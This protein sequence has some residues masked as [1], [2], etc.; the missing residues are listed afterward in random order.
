M[1]C[2]NR[3]CVSLFEKL[4]ITED[5]KKNLELEARK[6][7]L[8]LKITKEKVLDPLNE[9]HSTYHYFL[10][11]PCPFYNKKLSCSIHKNKP[12]MCQIFP[13]R[14]IKQISK[15]EYYFVIDPKCNW[16][17]NNLEIL[18]EPFRNLFNI[19]KNEFEIYLNS[20]SKILYLSL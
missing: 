19:F 12:V 13:I 11:L 7:N 10:H 9:E 14:N 20:I 5:E 4:Q 1:Q 6:R 16:V 18:E 15:K 3:C 2:E 8:E 17:K